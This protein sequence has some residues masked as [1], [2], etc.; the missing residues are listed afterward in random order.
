MY[1]AFCILCIAGAAYVPLRLIIQP[2]LPFFRWGESAAVSVMLLAALSGVCFILAF[3]F[4][5]GSSAWQFFEHVSLGEFFLQEGWNIGNAVLTGAFEGNFGALGLFWGTAYIGMFA[6]M[7]AWGIGYPAAIYAVCRPY[8]TRKL[9]I[10]CQVTAAVPSIAWGLAAILVVAPMVKGLFGGSSNSAFAAGLSMGC[11]LA[12][13]VCLLVIEGLQQI[14]KGQYEGAKSLGLDERQ[15]FAFIVRPQA[16]SYLRAALV[17]SASKALTETMVVLMAAGLRPQITLNPFQE[18]STVTVS[19]ANIMT[20]DLEFGHPVVLAS[21]ALLF[22]LVAASFSANLALSS[23]EGGRKHD[24]ARPAGSGFGWTVIFLPLWVWRV[25]NALAFGGVI[26]TPILLI[27][28]MGI[29]SLPALFE[30]HVHLHC[31]ESGTAPAF[32]LLSAKLETGATR[33]EKRVV[34]SLLADPNQEISCGDWVLAGDKLDSWY[35][36]TLLFLREVESDTPP[37]ADKLV[38]SGSLSLTLRL[39]V[40]TRADS[41]SPAFAGMGQAIV[42]TL[43]S[44]VLMLVLVVPIGLFTTVYLHFYLHSRGDVG[45][46]LANILES[47]TNAIMGFPVI[48]F[49]IIGQV[50]LIGVFGLPRGSGAVIALTLGMIAY[51]FIVLTGLAAIKGIPNK[52]AQEQAALALGMTKFEAV[53]KVVLPQASAGI[54]AGVIFALAHALG[55]TAALLPVGGKAFIANVDISPLA[56]T[57]TLAAQVYIW[58]ANPEGGFQSLAA[59]AALVLLLGCLGMALLGAIFSLRDEKRVNP[60]RPMKRKPPHRVVAAAST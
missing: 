7:V 41:S 2:R 21:F 48:A 15:G 22:V 12:P 34:K 31:E 8:L 50:L 9:K 24:L 29:T 16:A 23:Y 32:K 53:W 49:G 57:T 11:M 10:F 28:L 26:S 19:I 13:W 1:V 37:F 30:T 36:E 56:Q 58:A 59:L 3:F 40:F 43:W 51:P 5:S 54:A 52:I 25:R 35:K 4:I 38:D 27:G 45:K 55:E 47:S 14:P 39:S 20:G 60:Q 46:R 33:E 18:M 6:L 44:L 42:G 17:A